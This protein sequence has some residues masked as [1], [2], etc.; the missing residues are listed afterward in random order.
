MTDPSSNGPSNYEHSETFASLKGLKETLS[1]NYTS[2]QYLETLDSLIYKALEPIIQST[3]LFE[4]FVGQLMGWQESN[5]KRKVSFLDRHEFTQVALAW[6][7]LP[8]KIERSLQAK[9]MRI[10]RAALLEFLN[11]FLEQSQPY[12][13]A[14]DANLRGPDGKVLPLEEQLALRATYEEAFQSP[15]NLRPYILQTAYWT[16]L[17]ISLKQ[18]IVEKYVRYAL[19]HAQR[20]YTQVFDTKLKLNDLIQTYVLAIMRAIDKCDAR[21]GVLTPYIKHWFRTARAAHLEELEEANKTSSAEQDEDHDMDRKTDPHDFE[22]EQEIE[23]VRA[24]ARL[25][26]PEGYG[27]AYLGLS[28]SA[29]Y[30]TEQLERTL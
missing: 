14:C 25:V 27:R 6:F 28:E 16:G 19:I 29:T 1:G 9:Q 5:R 24:V 26:D 17:A 13:L 12:L 8:T 20:D 22:A 3:S 15:V 2:A 18:Q 7:L 21:Q 30:I 10:E 4:G 23:Q 11:T